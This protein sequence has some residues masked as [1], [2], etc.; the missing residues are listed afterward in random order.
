MPAARRAAATAHAARTE[1][2][3]G[4]DARNDRRA[5]ADFYR[6]GSIL[7]GARTK[8]RWPDRL[9]HIAYAGGWKKLEPMWDGVVRAR[10]AA[11][12]LPVLESVL[13]AFGGRPPA[14]PPAGPPAAAGRSVQTQHAAGVP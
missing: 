13:Q 4:A 2:S 7:R 5:Y 1:A 10:R 9:R 8:E 12:M 14:G 3:P 6:W 11:Q